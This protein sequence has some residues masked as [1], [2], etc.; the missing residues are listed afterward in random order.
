MT[1][2]GL[3]S[4]ALSALHAGAG[5]VLLAQQVPNIDRPHK[6]AVL[7]VIA[8][9]SAAFAGLGFGTYLSVDAALVTL[10]LPRSEDAARDLGMLDI[11]NA[12]PQVLAPLFAALII[13]HLA[14]YRVLF[15]MGGCCGIAGAIAVLTVRSV[16]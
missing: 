12:G 8:G 7:G 11:A 2:L 9:V 15:I 13:S 4:G 1:S 5:T 16:R 6:V 14:G 3:A 10:V